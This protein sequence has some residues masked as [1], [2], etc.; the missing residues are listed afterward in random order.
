MIAAAG[1][2]SRPAGSPG[3]AKLEREKNLEPYHPNPLPSCPAPQNFGPRRRSLHPAA[4]K[5]GTAVPV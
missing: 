2:M 1:E 3:R 4:G 5:Y